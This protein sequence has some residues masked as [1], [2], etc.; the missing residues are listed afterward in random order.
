MRRRSRAR[1][2][3]AAREAAP[4]RSLSEDRHRRQRDA[5]ESPEAIRHPGITD[6]VCL[7][8]EHERAA[9]CRRDP[10]CGPPARAARP[11]DEGRKRREPPADPE[12]R[13]EQPSLCA[14][15]RVVRLAG[16]DLGAG[17]GSG[18]AGIAEPVALRMVDDGAD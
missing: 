14:D 17:P 2:A 13:A 15:L 11:E 12:E 5:G 4:T 1:V 6:D 7:D 9:E 10:G 8:S 3:A 16:L 18:L